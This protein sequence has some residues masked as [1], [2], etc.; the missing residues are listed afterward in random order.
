MVEG[1]SLK[2]KIVDMKSEMKDLRNYIK[3]MKSG[4]KQE[5]E[6]I[7]MMFLSKK[8]MLINIINT[9]KK[10]VNSLN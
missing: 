9:L 7:R 1:L 3:T 4:N 6:N 2:H 8:A 10:K 5:L